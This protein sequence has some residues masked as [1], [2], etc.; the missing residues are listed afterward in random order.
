MGSPADSDDNKSASEE[1]DEELA[2]YLFGSL[3]GDASIGLGGILAEL[4]DLL[5][6]RGDGTT[7]LV[8]QDIWCEQQHN[9][10]TIAD[11]GT[12]VQ[13]LAQRI[14][15]E[16]RPEYRE[17]ASIAEVVEFIHRRIVPDLRSRRFQGT[18][19]EDL[20]GNFNACLRGEVPLATSESDP[21]A[22]SQANSVIS[23][24]WKIK[25]RPTGL[26]YSKQDSVKKTN[27]KKDPVKK[28]TRKRKASKSDEV[29]RAADS[30]FAWPF[31]KYVWSTRWTD[32]C[33][34]TGLCHQT[35]EA[36]EER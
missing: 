12:E 22:S 31:T 33:S 21:P 35:C 7:N 24:E 11:A 4:D 27:S 26:K 8:G 13:W 10:E 34:L 3:S 9:P 16:S 18:T 15:T 1:L 14:R 25:N 5:A 20:V 30:A 17:Q 28:T 32:D 2:G 36:Q 23:S 6:E 29:S 19:D